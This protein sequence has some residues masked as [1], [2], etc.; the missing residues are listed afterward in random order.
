METF[1]ALLAMCAGNSQ[2]T[3]EFPTQRPVT[4]GFDVFCDLRLN[5]RLSK[6]WRGWWSET[7]S[8]PLWRHSYA[9]WCVFGRYNDKKPRGASTSTPDKRRSRSRNRKN[10]RPGSKGPALA[11]STQKIVGFVMLMSFLI[12]IVACIMRFALFGN[13][14]EYRDDVIAWKLFLA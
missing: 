6:Q 5:K 9:I 1:S 8:R 2:V 3:G 7:P 10:G 11:R 13:Y 12:F 14:C 4:R